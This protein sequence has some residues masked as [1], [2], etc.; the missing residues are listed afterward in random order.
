VI[1]FDSICEYLIFFE[2]ITNISI[3]DTPIIRR[4]TIKM[5]SRNKSKKEYPDAK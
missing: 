1:S 2:T 4:E 5:K 3:T